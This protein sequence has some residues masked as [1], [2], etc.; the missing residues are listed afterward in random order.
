MNFSKTD[1]SAM[2]W[3]MWSETCKVI[4]EMDRYDVKMDRGWRWM[5]NREKYCVFKKYYYCCWQGN[6]FI[7]VDIFHLDLE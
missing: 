4:N 2:W 6:E 7:K 5:I 3:C 1:I